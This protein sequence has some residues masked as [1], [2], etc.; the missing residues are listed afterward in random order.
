MLCGSDSP[1]AQTRLEN[2]QTSVINAVSVSCLQESPQ[3]LLQPDESLL[4]GHPQAIAAAPQ[5]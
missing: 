2:S 4:T 5:A 3:V 1:A